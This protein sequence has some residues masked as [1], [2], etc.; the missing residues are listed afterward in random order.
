[1]WP[2]WMFEMGH[3]RLRC[4]LLLVVVRGIPMD[5][6]NCEVTPSLPPLLGTRRGEDKG[7]PQ[8]SDSEGQAIS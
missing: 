6:A 1:M 8:V 3:P 4:H 2:G 7:F 5:S